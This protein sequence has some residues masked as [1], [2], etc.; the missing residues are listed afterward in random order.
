MLS[1]SDAVVLLK[2]VVAVESK[3]TNNKDNKS[4]SLGISSSGMN[5]VATVWCGN[6]FL[7]LSTVN[8]CDEFICQ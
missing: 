5:A 8:K 3:I 1:E 4:S 6:N 7:V 2:I